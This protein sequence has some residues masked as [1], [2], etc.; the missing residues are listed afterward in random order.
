MIYLVRLNQTVN[1]LFE[2]ILGL[3][4]FVCF[5]KH[6]LNAIFVDDDGDDSTRFSYDTTG[7]IQGSLE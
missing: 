1:I 2:W 6:G 3:I 5:D 4:L 7:T